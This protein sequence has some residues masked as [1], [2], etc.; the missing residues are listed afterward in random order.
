MTQEIRGA[1]LS[2]IPQA[3]HGLLWEQPEATIQAITQFLD[4]M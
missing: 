2:V 4:Q 3:G 1:Q